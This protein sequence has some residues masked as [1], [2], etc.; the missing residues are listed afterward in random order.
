MKSTALGIDLDKSIFKLH[1]LDWEGAVF[2]QKK[3]RR[4]ALLTTLGRLK[5]CLI[6]MVACP[7][8]HFWAREIAALRYDV[9]LIPRA[10]VK[11][12]V[13]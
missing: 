9:R 4:G 12:Y 5:S 7:T 1:V 10:F 6:G 3:V 8:S 11:P 2:L 13:K